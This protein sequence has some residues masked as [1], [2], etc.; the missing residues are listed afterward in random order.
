VSGQIVLLAGPGDSTNIVYHYLRAR[1]GAVT[2]VVEDPVDRILLAR[3]RA[4]RLGWLKVSGQVAFVSLAMPLLRRAGSARIA[5]IVAA[6]DFST[7][8]IPGEHRVPSVNSHESMRL[9]AEIDPAV[10]VVN[11]TRII[12][13]TV[14]RAIR[15]PFINTHAGITPRYRGVHGGYWALREGRADLV[16]TTVHLVDPGIDTGGILGQGLFETGP[17]DSI[18]TYPYL[19]LACGLPV[20]GAVVEGVLNGGLP[21]QVGSR[22]VSGVSVLR[23]HPT[24][25]GYFVARMIKRVK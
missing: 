12:S 1:F 24:I 22:D 17:G 19:H 2:A 14:L 6:E 10:V 9:L 13:E 21:E 8:P 18:V 5:E 4:K 3:R 16:G 23:W 25:W 15:C 7:E 11:G 20:L